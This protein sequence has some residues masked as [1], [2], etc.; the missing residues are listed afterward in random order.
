MWAVP[1]EKLEA[2]DTPT[3]SGNRKIYE[4]TKAKYTKFAKD[5]IKRL[6]TLE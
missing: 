3:I 2:G 5:V 4:A 1:L 6:D